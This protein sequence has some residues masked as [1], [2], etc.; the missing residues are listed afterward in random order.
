MNDL[1]KVI[2]LLGLLMCAIGRL[3]WSGPGAAGLEMKT[4]VL[5]RKPENKE[6]SIRNSSFET[7]FQFL[8]SGF[9]T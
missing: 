7:F 4:Y 6:E 2:F 9:P 5:R 3:L 8:A 1:G